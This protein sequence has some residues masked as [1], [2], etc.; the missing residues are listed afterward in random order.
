MQFPTPNSHSGILDAALA[1]AKKRDEVTRQ[2]RAA[3]LRNDVSA[4]LDYARRL[5]GLSSES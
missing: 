2:M 3:L 1:I 4:V 5:C